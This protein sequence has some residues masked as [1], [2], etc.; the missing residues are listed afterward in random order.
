MG[1]GAVTSVSYSATLY[2]F[3]S[4]VISLPLSTVMFTELSVFASRGD[5]AKIKDYH[6]KTYK[7]IVFLC[8]PILI[9]V[10]FYSRDI[11]TII[12]GW[13]NFDANAI[14]Q[15]SLGL[16]AYIF[17]LIPAIVKSVLTRT[18][19]ALNDSKGPMIIGVLEVILNIGLSFVLVGHFGI[20]GVVGA[21]SI[22]SFTAMILMVISFNKKYVNILDKGWFTKYYNVFIAGII[23]TIIMTFWRNTFIVNLYVNFIVKSIFIFCIYILILVLK[24]EKF[25]EYIRFDS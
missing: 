22:A 7:L 17:C 13:G 5:M 19:Y 4:T 18:Y 6:A 20:L 8:I 12:Y 1:V 16:A 10:L 15:T 24:K 11:V 2:Q 3:A 23:C 14:R 9:E 25:S 21:T